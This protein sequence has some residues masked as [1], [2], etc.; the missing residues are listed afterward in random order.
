MV[1]RYAKNAKKL[2]K[3]LVKTGNGE[4]FARKSA[5]FV[6][7]K[8]L[9]EYLTGLIEMGLITRDQAKKIRLVKNADQFTSY[10]FTELGPARLRKFDMLGL[11]RIGKT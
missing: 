7:E 1:S 4:E 11:G 8:D 10:C 9:N 6:P 3:T 2:V 5:K